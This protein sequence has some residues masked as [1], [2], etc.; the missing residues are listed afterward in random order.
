MF[1]KYFAKFSND[2][3]I[4]LGTTNTLVS[5][6]GEGIVIN[7]PSVVAVQHD[8]FGKDKIL[9]VGHEAKLMIGKTPVN[10]QAVRPMKDGVIASGGALVAGY[11]EHKTALG[12]DME[13]NTKLCDLTG[14]GNK[15]THSALSNTDSTGFG[16]AA[17]ITV[18]GMK[19][20]I[21]AKRKEIYNSFDL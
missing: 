20:T 15:I 12:Y 5:L 18:R 7:E 10:I 8:R 9:A 11:K 3:G 17:T 13:L 1:R 16:M 14:R 19:A 4:D 2:I 6:S 21:A